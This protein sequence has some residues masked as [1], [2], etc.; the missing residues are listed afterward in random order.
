MAPL[1]N[2]DTSDAAAQTSAALRF[3][4]PRT[5]VGQIG[6][7][8]RSTLGVTLFDVA[9]GE[10]VVSAALIPA[11][12]DGDEAGAADELESDMATT[13]KP[14]RSAPSSNLPRRRYP[15]W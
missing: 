12:D 1:S 6:I 2:T 13:R 8:G 7:K 9:D 14:T 15:C 11:D 3:A 5:L 10:H 4:T